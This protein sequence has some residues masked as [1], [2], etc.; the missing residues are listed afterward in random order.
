MQ[1][2]NPTVT[3]IAI[4]TTLRFFVSVTFRGVVI[5]SRELG[6]TE[7]HFRTFGRRTT[8]PTSAKRTAGS[9]AAARLRVETKWTRGWSISLGPAFS[10]TTLS[11]SYKSNFHSYRTSLVLLAASGPVFRQTTGR[12][13]FLT[14]NLPA[15][16]SYYGCPKVS[17]DWRLVLRLRKVLCS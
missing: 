11:D 7:W 1:I 4:L 15:K 6:G 16:S 9:V 2:I 14:T 10:Y 3:D 8:E 12:Q 5:A 13:H 17:W